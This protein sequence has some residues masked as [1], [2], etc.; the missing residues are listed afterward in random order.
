VVNWARFVKVELDRWPAIKAFHARVKA[1]PA[2][3][4]AIKAES[5][6]KAA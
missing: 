4:A 3:Q 6:T 2:V 5:P 1:R